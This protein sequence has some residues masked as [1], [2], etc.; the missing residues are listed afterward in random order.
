MPKA[1]VKSPTP[2]PQQ[3]L[4][5][6]TLGEFVRAARTQANMNIHAAAAFC[7]VAVGTMQKIETVSGDVRLSSIL[8]VCRM[9]GIKLDIRCSTPGTAR[10]PAGE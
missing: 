3:L 8:T 10:E 5:A 1:V 9:L 2:A 6:K 7:G 4:D